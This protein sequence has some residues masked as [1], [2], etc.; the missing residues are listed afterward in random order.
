ME[1]VIDPPG[2]PKAPDRWAVSVMLAPTIADVV[3]VVV[4]LGVAGLTVEVSPESLQAVL[5][6][7]LLVSPL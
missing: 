5:T 1:N 4:R 3:A 6:E 7:A 2:V